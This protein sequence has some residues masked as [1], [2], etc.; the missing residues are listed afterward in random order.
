[1][2]HGEPLP[3]GDFL[4]GSIR[5]AVHGGSTPTA[6]RLNNRSTRGV[7][8]RNP[9]CAARLVEAPGEGAAVRATALPG[10]AVRA[11]DQ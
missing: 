10:R 3:V 11:V 5:K 7:I 1:V 8:T 4:T 2:L 9:G 6:G